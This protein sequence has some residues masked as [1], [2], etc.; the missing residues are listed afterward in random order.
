[1]R[2]HIQLPQTALGEEAPLQIRRGKLPPFLSEADTA[3]FKSQAFLPHLV[4]GISIDLALVKL[5]NEF[6]PTFHSKFEP[7]EID[8]LRDSG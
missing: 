1:M 7:T 4:N 6:K 5:K 2:M 8:L 3:A